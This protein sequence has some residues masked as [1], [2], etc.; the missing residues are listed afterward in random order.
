MAGILLLNCPICCLLAW[1]SF[2]S[3]S[4][5]DSDKELQIN[6][7][8]EYCFFFPQKNRFSEFLICS[9]KINIPLNWT[10]KIQGPGGVSEVPD[11]CLIEQWCETPYLTGCGELPLHPK[12]WE[13]SN[14][15]QMLAPHIPG[16][17]WVQA[18]LKG[19]CWP[20]GSPSSASVEK[21]ATTSHGG[22]SCCLEHLL[23]GS[24]S[25]GL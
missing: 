20:S 15:A 3:V 23:D 4:T 13:I 11:P 25:Q 12:S 18:P 24:D 14:S 10:V 9:R 16:P 1:K 8:F 6:L 7:C 2:S 22:H 21:K 19:A 5:L 17:V